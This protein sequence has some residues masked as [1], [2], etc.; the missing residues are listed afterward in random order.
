MSH[1]IVHVEFSAG[2]LKA[3]SQF[4]QEIFD[5]QMQA[6]PEMNYV[7]F[8]WGAEDAG[9]GFNPVQEGYPAGTVIVYI[10]TDDINAT[11]EAVGERGGETLEPPMPIPGVGQIA[12]F[13]DPTGNR[14]GLIQPG[15]GEG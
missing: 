10:Q 14:V 7:S 15:D 11:L 4:Y 12:I 8:N 2:D 3:A 6:F 5:W 13:R 1:P 9:G